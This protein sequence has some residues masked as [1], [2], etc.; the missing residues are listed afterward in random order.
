MIHGAKTGAKEPFSRGAFRTIP[1]FDGAGETSRLLGEDLRLERRVQ[2]WRLAVLVLL[3]SVPLGSLF[4]EGPRP[5]HQWSLVVAGTAIALTLLAL[6]SLHKLRRTAW[7]RYAIT[8]AD[9]TMATALLA[10]YLFLGRP[11]M[12]VNSQVTF[13]IYFLILCL[14]ACRHDLSLA[15]FGAALTLLEYL[16]LIGAGAILWDLPAAPPDPV[17]GSFH[18][19]N[20]V[21]R[22][23]VLA[24]ASALTVLAV[25]NSREVRELSLRDSLTGIHNRRFFEEALDLEFLHS[26]ERKEPLSLVLLDVDRFKEYNDR[27]GHPFGDRILTAVADFLWR[28]LRR[29]DVLA[30]YGGD[31]FAIL[32]PSTTGEEAVETLNRLKG[33]MEQWFHGLVPPGHPELSFSL[34]LAC[35]NEKDRTAQDLLDRADRHLYRSKEAGG[36]A[37][38]C[39]DG[40]L[41]DGNAGSFPFGGNPGLQEPKER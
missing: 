2:H 32:L 26:G 11:M 8:F 9:V 40:R 39:H 13:L 12:A 5:E 35:R 14:I 31:E 19:A 21:G 3:L 29:S 7:I 6:R 30:R 27:L 17:Y 36:G 41:G 4:Q 22:F 25:R 34:G 23:S 33:S 38:C 10:S 28:H 16:A 37:I 18:W 20:Q 15:L 1:R 24:L